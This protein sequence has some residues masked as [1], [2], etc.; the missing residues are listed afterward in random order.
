LADLGLEEDKMSSRFLAVGL[1]GAGLVISAGQAALAFLPGEC[2]SDSYKS[3]FKESPLIVIGRVTAI[4]RYRHPY[5]S[6][7]DVKESFYLATITVGRTMKGDAKPGQEIL[8]LMGFSHLRADD[9]LHSSILVVANTHAGWDLEIDNSYLICLRPSVY[10]SDRAHCEV[11]RDG[12]WQGTDLEKRDVWEPR[13]CHNSV[14]RVSG[15]KPEEVSLYLEWSRLHHEEQ[16]MPL[17]Q[18][19]S[20]N[21]KGTTRGTDRGQTDLHTLDAKKP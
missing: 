19:I 9:N 11:R 12:A 14:H 4:E 18:F 6:G 20:E 17:E 10:L 7:S 2:V 16:R 5:R 13:S 3:D 21:L 8:F 15:K 1:L